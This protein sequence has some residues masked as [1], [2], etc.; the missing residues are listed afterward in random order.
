MNRTVKE[1][2]KPT[3]ALPG[4]PLA[5]QCHPLV[6]HVGLDHE[7]S[8]ED[9][10]WYPGPFRTGQPSGSSVPRGAEMAGAVAPRAIEVNVF[11]MT[12]TR[13]GQIH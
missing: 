5:V 2:Y 3:C 4:T 10:R 1:G 13:L 6:L 11:A 8:P 12:S 7:H 9:V